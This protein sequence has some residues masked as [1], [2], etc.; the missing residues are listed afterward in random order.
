MDFDAAALL[1]CTKATLVRQL[2]EIA[3]HHFEGLQAAARFKSLKL[4]NRHRRQLC[5]LDIAF[6]WSR[7]VN[8]VKCDML[9]IDIL[10]HASPTT[11]APAYEYVAP[12]HTFTDLENVLET[13]VL[14]VHPA[15][16]PVIEYVAPAPDVTLATPAPVIEYAAPAHTV[17]FTAPSPVTEDVAP[18]PSSSCAAPASLIEFVAPATPETVNANVAPAPVIEYS[19]APPAEFYP[20]CSQQL[21]PADT[22]EVVAV[23]AAA[24]QDVGSLLPLDRQIMNI[25]F[26]RCMEETDDVIEDQIFDAPVPQTMEEQLVAVTPTPAT[27]DATFPIKKWMKLARSRP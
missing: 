18:A 22:N 3:G 27:T 7:H 12:A 10:S 26:P 8:S 2:S 15:P 16:A 24:P 25:P 20:S 1:A 19:A 14:V 23:E 5:H 21:P 13:P 4:T 6:N 9:L 17:T 11:A